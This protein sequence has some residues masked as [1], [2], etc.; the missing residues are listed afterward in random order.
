VKNYYSTTKTPRK[1]IAN[2]ESPKKHPVAGVIAGNAATPDEH[3]VAATKQRHNHKTLA[4]SNLTSPSEIVKSKKRQAGAEVESS[5]DVS[6]GHDWAHNLEQRLMES[7]TK[8][9]QKMEQRMKENNAILQQEMVELQ[10]G[11]EQRMIENSAALQQEMNKL[12]KGMVD[13]RQIMNAHSAAMIQLS[14][15]TARYTNQTLRDNQ[16]IFPVP[17]HKGN[18]PPTDLFPRYQSDISNMSLPQVEALLQF[19]K[20]IFLRGATLDEKKALLCTHLGLVEKF[21]S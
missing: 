6:V 20:I 15:Q 13:L 1:A 17:N 12:Q 14:I 8:L 3:I 21:E 18:P 11:M 16:T 9:Q 7:N 4:V 5:R 10:Q 2:V 19:Y